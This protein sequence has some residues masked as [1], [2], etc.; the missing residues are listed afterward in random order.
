MGSQKPPQPVRPSGAVAV[1]E[2]FLDTGKLAAQ[3]SDIVADTVVNKLTA[4]GLTAENIK[5][6]ERL[7]AAPPLDAVAVGGG[8][9]VASLADAV[10]GQLTAIGLTE[11]NVKQLATLEGGTRSLTLGKGSQMARQLLH[12]DDTDN[13]AFPSSSFTEDPFDS[14][15][16]ATESNRE[17]SLP[18]SQMSMCRRKYL[19]ER[20]VLGDTSQSATPSC[21]PQKKLHPF[22]TLPRLYDS[23]TRFSRQRKR[24]ALSEV[25]TREEAMCPRPKKRKR[26]DEVDDAKDEFSTES[27]TDTHTKESQCEERSR[28]F[29]AGG[30][31]QVEILPR[32]L[33]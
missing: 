17:G 13:S 11:K 8:S 15:T 30:E 22:D 31:F 28:R 4:I 12:L 33:N 32:W 6:L 14:S 3:V 7:E 9:Q 25:I 10:L 27:D 24:A 29:R 18:S 26:Q 1:C 2:K 21:P 19:G 20:P 23:P 5:K 16:W